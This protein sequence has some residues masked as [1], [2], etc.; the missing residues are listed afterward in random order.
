MFIYEIVIYE[1]YYFE[2]IFPSKT[3]SSRKNQKKLQPL[4]K[5]KFICVQITLLTHL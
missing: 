1:I 3:K 2:I 4:T 5:L